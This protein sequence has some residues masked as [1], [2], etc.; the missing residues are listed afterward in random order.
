MNVKNYRIMSLALVSLLAGC[1]TDPYNA[2]DQLATEQAR[3]SERVDGIERKIDNQSLLEMSRKLDA[4]ELEVRTLRGDIESLQFELQG[5]NSRQRDQYVDIDSRL[6]GLESGR[7]AAPAV[8]G[9]VAAEG[10]GAAAASVPV[11]G[12]ASASEQESYNAAFN[13][14]KDGRYEPAAAAFDQFLKTYPG[15]NL[16]DNAKYWYAETFYVR[17][18]FA[19]ALS[20]FQSVVKDYPDSRKTPDALL[21]IGYCNYEL[22]QWKA[23]RAA[24]TE[25]SKRFPDSTAARLADQRLQKMQSEGH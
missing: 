5:L 7:V 19:E 6:Q 21:K 23:A 25:A 10:A 13:A 8:A 4:M 15:S 3:L 16:A 18:Q 9:A 12:P 14:L 1:A 11:T 17:R 22:Q 2:E 20:T 24:L